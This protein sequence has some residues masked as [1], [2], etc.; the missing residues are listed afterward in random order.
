MKFISGILSPY[1]SL[2]FL[3]DYLPFAY[4]TPNFFIN[5]PN[6]R[7]LYY[8]GCCS[9]AKSYLTLCDPVDCSTPGFS[10]LHYLPEFAQTHVH[11]ISDA[12]SFSVVLFSS[13]LQ[14]FPASGSL[15]TSW[16]CTLG[17]QSIG[18]SA[19]ASV[20]PMSIQDWSPLGWKEMGMHTCE[21]F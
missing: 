5:R 11:W 16:F 9:V 13:H 6:S 19:S 18:A 4:T 17:S 8:C 15:L 10:V 12:I 3:S 7:E 20:L 14:S 2:S 1:Q 21:V